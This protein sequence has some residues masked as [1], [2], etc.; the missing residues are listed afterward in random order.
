MP[1][2]ILHFLS[3]FTID[4]N[5]YA[6]QLKA[7]LSAGRNVCCDVTGTQSH[8]RNSVT[9]PT[10]MREMRRF[11]EDPTKLGTMCLSASVSEWLLSLRNNKYFLT[12]CTKTCLVRSLFRLFSS[13]NQ[14]AR[15]YRFEIVFNANPTHTHTHNSWRKLQLLQNYDM[16]YCFHF[17]FWNW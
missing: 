4:N 1:I 14:K 15:D 12:Q 6:S 5:D 3:T 9:Q 13:I 16:K 10:D 11:E 8:W 7:E 17:L 2:L